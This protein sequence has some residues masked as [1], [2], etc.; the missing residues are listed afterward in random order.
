MGIKSIIFVCNKLNAGGME[1][2]SI[3]EKQ[4]FL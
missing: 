4:Q 1:Q 2:Q 3:G